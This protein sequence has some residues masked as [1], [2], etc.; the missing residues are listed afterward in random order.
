MLNV[1]DIFFHFREHELVEV[2]DTRWV[3]HE[4]AAST[5]IK[6]LGVCLLA[7]QQL[8]EAGNDDAKRIKQ[9]C[10]NHALLALFLLAEV[11]PILVAFSRTLQRQ[12]VCWLEITNLKIQ[13]IESIA[14]LHLRDHPSEYPIYNNA[15]CCINNARPPS[16]GEDIDYA[17][18]L[19]FHSTHAKPYLTTLKI[20]RS[21][22]IVR[23]GC[24]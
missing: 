7:V 19:Q 23:Y 14:H 20:G 3:S 22:N 1:V 18:F 10:S 5:L 2:A 24:V 15:F 17:F 12:D 9:A 6:V 21:S 4:R 13:Y 11:C 8:V 16:W